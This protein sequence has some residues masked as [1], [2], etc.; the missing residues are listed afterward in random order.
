MSATFDFDRMLR[1]TLEDAGPSA[2]PIELID[3]AL[4]RA[5]SERQRRPVVAL[6]D[7]RAWPAPSASL[8][9][10][11]LARV[12]TISLV[13]LLL[14]ALAVAAITVGSQLFQRRVPA[15]FWSTTGALNQARSDGSALVLLADGRVLVAGGG[16]LSPNSI[17]AT[18]IYDAAGNTW[19]PGR[20][21]LH[22]RSRATATRLAD[23]R[24]LVTGGATSG[25]RVKTAEIFDPKTGAWTATGSMREARS[26][27]AAILLPDGRVL[28]AGGTDGDDAPPLEAELYDPTSG[29]WSATGVMTIWR[30]SPSITLLLDGTVLVAGGF[31]PG[32]RL[33]TAEIYHPA[34]GTWT[35]TGNMTQFRSDDHTATLLADGRVLVAGGPGSTAEI[36]DPVT[37]VWS[38]ATDMAGSEGGHTATRLPSGVVLFT[39]GLRDGAALRLAQTYDPATASWSPT[40]SLLQARIGA[41]GV[42]LQDGSVLV[43][44]GTDTEGAELSSAEIYRAGS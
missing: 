32:I 14:V 29:T 31:G 41:L 16:P 3:A 13:V 5:R 10:P 36:F 44:G 17:P 12:A 19:I 1:S 43:I 26:Q 8:A 24:V 11:V 30:A 35:G 38:K 18:E 9:N 15:P 21:L 7:R 40:T 6:L 28:V 37:H 42:L 23:G 39:G 25:V 2:A 34:S 4:I 33:R 27:H 20:D 22:P